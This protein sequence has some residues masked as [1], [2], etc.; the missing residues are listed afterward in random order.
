[1]DLYFMRHAEAASSG[2]DDFQ[3]PLTPEGRATVAAEA[4]GLAAFGLVPDQILTSPLFRA[5]QTAEIVGAVLAVPV[6]QCAALA[7]GCNLKLLAEALQEHTSHASLMVVGHQPDLAT[8]IGQLIGRDSAAVAMGKGAVAIVQIPGMVAPGNGVLC[9]LLPA[10]LL[11]A[12]SA[13]SS[14]G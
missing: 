4:R 7:S 3:R 1:M 6:A 10:E 2:A 5:C 13:P 14:L 9:C 11:C 8:M 12:A